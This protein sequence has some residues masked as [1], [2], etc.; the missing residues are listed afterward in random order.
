M[1]RNTALT[2]KRV[3]ALITGGA[4]YFAYAMFM[5]KRANGLRSGL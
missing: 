1:N 4:R 2:I 5:F 3:H